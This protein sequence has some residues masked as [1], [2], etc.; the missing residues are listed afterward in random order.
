MFNLNRQLISSTSVDERSVGEKKPPSSISPRPTH[1][2]NSF[3][4]F[5]SSSTVSQPHQCSSYSSYSH[6]CL[7]P[8]PSST[9]T[10]ST[11]SPQVP[12]TISPKSPA[13][14]SRLIRARKPQSGRAIAY[15]EL[16]PHVPAA[17]RIFSWRTPF[18]S[19]HQADV[20]QRLPPPLVES[21]MMAVRG[22]LA[23]N[24]KS[25]YA[26][27]PLCFTQFCDKWVSRRR[28]ICQLTM[29]SYVPS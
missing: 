2:R 13:S 4:P 7:L 22:A 3:H 19:R 27:G 14:S 11:T 9:P 29:P 1:P 5:Q 28:L 18:G 8:V 17:E 20:A 16:R 6:P 25:T 15:N 21:A 26:A 12:L 23:P 10:A 24:A